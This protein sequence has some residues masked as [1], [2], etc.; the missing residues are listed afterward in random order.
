M[1]AAAKICGAVDSH[2]RDGG[3]WQTLSAM[4]ECLGCLP[5]SRVSDAA[6]RLQVSR[7]DVGRLLE[8]G[9]LTRL[10]RYLVVGACLTEQA[11]SDD[12]L[13]HRLEAEALL[14]TY[15]DCVA[16][17]HSAAVLRGLPTFELPSYATATRA[18]GA[19]RGGNRRVR[20]APLPAHHVDSIDG[21]S[22]TSAAR[23]VVDIA[24][25]SS[26]RSAAVTGDAAL[27]A[28]LLKS[29]LKSMVDE[30]AAWSDVGKASMAVEFMDARA[31]S[32]L[33]S[34]SRVVFHERGVPPP[35]PQVEI[36]VAG[37]VYRVDFLWKE[38]RV[39]GEADG[40]GKYSLDPFRT[41]EQVVWAEKLREDALRDA[42]YILV[43]WTYG[44]LLN[45]TDAVVDRILRRLR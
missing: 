10:D 44:Q 43:R 27:R 30:C 3:T 16:S 26:L 13:A 19:W 23:T 1:V 9:V 8:S 37:V 5:V 17:A 41:A 36:V 38:A 32:P 24:R 7:R 14:A 4:S 21:K 11:R 40:R 45:E 15:P 31:E 20:I 35:E 42:G 25:T 18:E 2:W 28:G 6:S 33:E 39:I 22:V 12:T 29:D 34:L